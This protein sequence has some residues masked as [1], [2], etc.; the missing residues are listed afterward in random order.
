MDFSTA[1]FVYAQ[2]PQQTYGQEEVDY[3]NMTFWSTPATGAPQQQGAPQYAGGYKPSPLP[4]DAQPRF[5]DSVSRMR[6]G[7]EM[8]M[9][10]GKGMAVAMEMGMEYWPQGTTTIS[11]TGSGSYDAAVGGNGGNG[12]GYAYGQISPTQLPYHSDSTT[13]SSTSSPPFNGQ[14]GYMG[15]PMPAQT[16]VYHPQYT[17]A[18]TAMPAMAT[19]SSYVIGNGHLGRGIQHPYAPQPE[20]LPAM[21]Q[22]PLPA[23]GTLPNT[24]SSSDE[25]DVVVPGSSTVVGPTDEGSSTVRN[26]RSSVLLCLVLYPPGVTVRGGVVVVVVVVVVAVVVVFNLLFLPPSPRDRPCCLYPECRDEH[27][28]PTHFFSR[29]ADLKR[30]IKSRH[31]GVY[32]DCVVR[33]CNRKGTNGFTRKDHRAEH[34]RNVHTAV[35]AGGK[36][37]ARATVRAGRASGGGGGVDG[38]GG[39]LYPPRPEEEREEEGELRGG[40]GPVVDAHQRQRPRIR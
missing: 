35:V 13:T 14:M 23:W 37:P 20:M 25:Q 26:K 19:G 30:H 5:G 8:R 11:P 32:L 28:N 16:M 31:E 17:T 2:P 3:P 10:M 12:C 40:W 18:S 29:N 27:N 21:G 24:A 1:T 9:G 7:M 33:E 22:L 15:G 38:G 6:V 39:Y 36:S 34:I 4:F